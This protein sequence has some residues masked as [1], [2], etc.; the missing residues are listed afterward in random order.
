MA[1]A[2]KQS[3]N[4]T[5]IEKLSMH[6]KTAKKKLLENKA[7]EFNALIKLYYQ[8]RLEQRIPTDTELAKLFDT[9]T[10]PSKAALYGALDIAQST[11]NTATM[12]I[13]Q[14]LE[15]LGLTW[16]QRRDLT[17]KAKLYNKHV[18]DMN[19]LKAMLIVIMKNNK[20]KS[21]VQFLNK[22][23]KEEYV[24]NT[25]ATYWN[26]HA[27]YLEANP[28]A[29]T[30][31]TTPKVTVPRTGTNFTP[32]KVPRYDTNN[33]VSAKQR[34]TTVYYANPKN[35]PIGPPLKNIC[36]F[37]NYFKNGCNVGPNHSLKHVCCEPGCGASHPAM[38]HK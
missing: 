33:T 7:I 30:T 13:N 16:V 29:P 22:L 24:S 26:R 11:L 23:F 19:Q 14:K 10:Q 4:E 28:T 25:M 18:N 12:E 15:D 31:K 37:Y 20:L 32:N 5:N 36:W 35:E 9:K 17:E 34:K 38:H 1:M 2:F 27:Y 3:V 21:V 8:E 6:S